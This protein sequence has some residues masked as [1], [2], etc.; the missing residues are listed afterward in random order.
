[1]PD[2]TQKTLKPCCP[3][4]GGRIGDS[5]LLCGPVS[6]VYLG[7]FKWYCANASKNDGKAWLTNT[8]H[9]TP[10]QANADTLYAELKKVEW[11]QRVFPYS[12]IAYTT[13]S[14]CQALDDDGHAPDCTLSAALISARG[15]G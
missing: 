15:D 6:G 1:M 10:A 7:S 12:R 2:N 8:R 3:F 14:C 4:C 13:C 5:Y 9:L 11:M